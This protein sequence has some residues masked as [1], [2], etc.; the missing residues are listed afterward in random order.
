MEAYKERVWAEIDLDA[1]AYN[2]KEIRKRTKP[3][4]KI[5]TVVKTDAYGHGAVEIAETLLENGADCLAV[6]MLDEAVELRRSGITAP[7]LILGLTHPEYYEAV[8]REEVAQTVDSFEQAEALSKAATGLG[9]KAVVHLKLDTGMGRIGFTC[10]ESDVEEIKRIVSL[11]NLSVEGVFTHFAK[12]DEADPAYTQEQFG[13]FMGFLERL[14]KEGVHIPVRHVSN[15]A[16]TLRFPE[17]HLEMVRPGIILYGYYPSGDFEKGIADLRPVMSLRARITHI[18]EMSE[19]ETV[20]YGGTY[21]VKGRQKIATV[22]VGYG[23]GYF[24]ILSGKAKMLVKG[25]TVPVVGRICMD[26]SMID[27]SSVHTIHVGDEVVIFGHEG[28][29]TLSLDA[30]AEEAGTIP[31]ELLCAV[32]RRVPRVYLKGGK[33]VRVHNSLNAVTKEQGPGKD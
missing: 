12:A 8:I 14:E 3:E 6:A 2:M 22:P 23:D 21:Q 31:Y 10:R 1:L 20:S 7:I 17:M 18:K 29:K 25:E 27:V 4:A 30:L 9:K 11:P 32:S 24:R 33:V 28:G 5:M 13:R 19:G 15:S 16:A 26:Q